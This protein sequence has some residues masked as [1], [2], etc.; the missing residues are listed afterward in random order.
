MRYKYDNAVFNEYGDFVGMRVQPGDFVHI[1]RTERQ[2][3]PTETG[4]GRSNAHGQWENNVA[5]YNVGWEV[6][7]KT[8]HNMIITRNP[9]RDEINGLGP[10]SEYAY[11]MRDNKFIAS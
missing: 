9:T 5:H 2:R 1:S 7:T 8:T 4:V 11:H 6:V 3:G 10:A